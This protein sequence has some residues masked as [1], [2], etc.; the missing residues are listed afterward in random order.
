MPKHSTQISRVTR[1]K[2]EA[3]TAYNRLSRW[4]DLLA[5]PSEQKH[6]R[7]ALQLLAVHEGAVALEVGCGT[8]HSLLALAQDVGV[9]GRVYGLDLSEKM[10]NRSWQRISKAGLSGRVVLTCA[11]GAS[12][13][14]Q[15]ASVDAVLVCFTLEL[16]DT[17]EIPLVLFECR[18]VLRS[19]GRM[20]VVALSKGSNNLPERLYE[21]AHRA[22][23]A[24]ADCRPIYPRAALEEA[25]FHI[26][27]VHEF[28]M[29]GLP[30]ETVLALKIDPAVNQQPA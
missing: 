14:V 9:S 25:G 30:G 18:R 2:K 17:P 24:F 10:L 21:W 1:A 19:S 23:P 15:S 28:S 13:P 4:Y 22:F 5:G 6:A 11:D 16:F 3:R 12:L 29:A 27:A 20:V 7:F 8:G 26:L